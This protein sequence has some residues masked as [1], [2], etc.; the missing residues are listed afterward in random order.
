M[1]C[2]SASWRIVVAWF[3]QV[4]VDGVAKTMTHVRRLV[5]L[6]TLS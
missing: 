1:S 5:T 6:L 4:L 3:L 2:R